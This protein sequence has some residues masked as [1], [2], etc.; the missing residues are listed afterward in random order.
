MKKFALL[1]ALSGFTA[2]MHADIITDSIKDH[3]YDTLKVIIAVGTTNNSFA[4]TKDQKEQ[5]REL[6]QAEVEKCT[7]KCAKYCPFDSVTGV[8]WLSL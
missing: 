3:D 2:A 1:L 5:Y 8:D 6:A 7:Q 4:V